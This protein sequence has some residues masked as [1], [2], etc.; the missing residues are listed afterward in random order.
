VEGGALTGGWER[1]ERSSGLSQNEPATD[2][3]G[4]AAGSGNGATIS[5]IG[6]VVLDAGA[7]TGFVDGVSRSP[8]AAVSEVAIVALGTGVVDVDPPCF[9]QNAP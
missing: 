3:V 8:N 6:V 9:S 2:L 7:G 1:V 5:G 4:R